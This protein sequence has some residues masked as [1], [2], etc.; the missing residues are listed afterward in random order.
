ML[1]YSMWTNPCMRISACYYAAAGGD[2][3]VGAAAAGTYHVS[4]EALNCCQGLLRCSHLHE[5]KAFVLASVPV[6]AQHMS[7]VFQVANACDRACTTQNP[8][9][10]LCRRTPLPD[11][12]PP[13]HT[14]TIQTLSAHLPSYPCPPYLS[15]MTL[16]SSTSPQPLNTR[17]KMSSST[18][19]ATPPMYSPRGSSSSRSSRRLSRCPRPSRPR[20][21]PS[22]NSP[23]NSLQQCGAGK[24]T[25]ST[26]LFTW[27]VH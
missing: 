8:W 6:S 16:H 18:A 27:V 11:N 13:N 12:C 15:T 26:P 22:S 10:P 2:T 20:G 21:G 25:V 5:G 19:C 9:E 3:T 24:T 14:D 4:I 23:R 17:A 1:V 7:A